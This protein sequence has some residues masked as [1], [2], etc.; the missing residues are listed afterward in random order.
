MNKLNTTS[1]SLAVTP[2]VLSTLFSH[3]LNR[4]PLRERPTAH[5]SYD[6]GLHLIR[7]FLDFA[8][9]HTIEE[10]QAFTAQW[11]PR[12]QWVKVDDVSVP[13]KLLNRSAELLRDELGPEGIRQVGGQQ[14]WQWRN[15]K[16]SLEAEWIEMRT[17]AHQRKKTGDPGRRVMMYIH[18]G[19]YFFGSVD[20]HRYQMQRHARKLQARVFAPKYRLA[21][22]FPFPCGLQDCLAAYLFLLETQ[23]PSTI[24]LA[25]DSAGGGMVM[26]ILCILRNQGI[27]LPAGAIL[28]SPWVD[29]TH[30]FPSVAGESPF[31]YIPQAGFHHKPSRA[32]PPP[33]ADD[34]QVLRV[35]AEKEKD[36]HK[37]SANASELEAKQQAPVVPKAGASSN[38][39]G[40]HE[41]T[42]GGVHTDTERFLTVMIG[43]ELVTVK[44][45]IQMYTTNALLSHPLVSPVMQPTLGGLPPLLIMVGG[46]EILQDEQIYLAHK[47]ANPEK[48]AP[49]P[50]TLTGKG[51]ELLAKHKPTD[52]HLQVW[53]DLC[54]VAP[55]LSFTRPAKHMYRSVSQ[56]GAWALARAQKRGIDILDD[57]NISVIT[58][59]GSDTEAPKDEKKLEEEEQTT[60]GQVGKAGDPLPP[61]KEHMIRQRITRHGATLPLA[62]ESELPGCCIKP[63]EVGVIKAGPVKK[64]MARKRQWDARYSAAKAKVHKKIITDIATGFKDFG[65]GE[66]PPPSALA[67]RRVET[68]QPEKKRT[69]SIG[70]ALWSSWGSKHDETTVGRQRRAE[71]GPDMQS[72]TG[73]DGAGARSSADIEAQQPAPPAA[74]ATG[75]NRSRRR[76]VIDDNQ[77][78]RD[79]VGE[80][81][82]VA[83]L[84][85]MPRA[86]ESSPGLLNPTY[87]PET[88][89][90]G[91]RPFLGG[92]AMPF[93]L[94][95]D[96]E[97]ASMVTLNSSVSPAI[98]PGPVGSRMDLSAKPE[99][100]NEARAEQ[101]LAAGT[102]RPKLASVVGA[103]GG[104][105][106][107]E[108]EKVKG[109]VASVG[110]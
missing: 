102:E 103:E 31:D 106:N 8:S 107:M 65:P 37:K 26:S 4:K 80:A 108:K 23:D 13:E 78:G 93:S 6:Q 3:F 71:Q 57:G 52:V 58:S 11:V 96:A 86:K 104:V 73:A 47:C 12:P 32:W 74:D 60:P 40:G 16:S 110:V 19:A 94:G 50:E 15:T 54:H 84:L 89:V 82:P 2:T 25:G 67:G 76:T 88:G 99:P 9:H 81:I 56:F 30:S 109:E 98:S 35:E 20:E 91:R 77:T 66:H 43:G 83:T 63:N 33:N 42:S 41:A 7:S 61:F 34:S 75:R 45:Q 59:S 64:W 105:P 55:T 72:G 87:V 70:L 1:V 53:D 62:P 5:L 22:Q 51:R 38:E 24:V 18:G 39:P 36:R 46:G 10:L 97:T 27:A 92:I 69:K 49:S 79:Q 14:W 17:D 95:K 68:D 44:D 29:L 90:A 28:I 85:A 100:E 48:Y 101:M 21:P